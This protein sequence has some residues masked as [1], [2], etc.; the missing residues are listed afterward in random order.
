MKT[1][2][3]LIC[4]SLVGSLLSLVAARESLACSG[5]CYEGA[6]LPSQKDVPASIPGIF[7]NA[8]VGGNFPLPSDVT[9][10][11]VTA[12]GKVPVPF[13]GTQYNQ[14]I[15]QLVLVP[16]EPLLP[17][18]DYEIVDSVSCI[19]GNTPIQTTFHTTDLL[20][21]PKTLGTLLIRQ[22]SLSALDLSSAEGGCST[23]I[24]TLNSQI[25]LVPSAEALPF[26]H[27]FY[28]ETIVDGKL[29]QPSHN[30]LDI[31]PPGASWEGRGQDLLYTTCGFE[32]PSGVGTPLAEGEHTV[33]IRAKLQGSDFVIDSEPGT[34]TLKCPEVVDESE[35]IIESP[36]CQ[37]ISPGFGGAYR[38]WM[39]ISLAIGVLMAWRQRRLPN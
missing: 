3:L 36:G 27:A 5:G 19:P 12:M 13:T 7:W 22:P 28:Y 29:W 23:R 1:K 26:A 37:L 6:F 32:P 33:V 38:G 34:V 16:N 2:T 18:T 10:Y 17:N 24:M 11:Q 14:N 39:T 15:N 21:F 25:E 30:I 35:L 20:P 8:R 4:S 31:N 9:L